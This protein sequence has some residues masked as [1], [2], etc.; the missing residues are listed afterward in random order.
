[1][2]NSAIQGIGLI[3]N[4]IRF[5][6]DYELARSTPLGDARSRQ[7][8]SMRLSLPQ[9]ETTESY[10]SGFSNMRGKSSVVR[11]SISGSARLELH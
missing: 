6:Q 11:I 5:T 10:S 4:I 2:L 8:T 3:V 1:M 7:K 9:H